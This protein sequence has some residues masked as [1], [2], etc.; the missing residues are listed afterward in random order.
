MSVLFRRLSDE[1]V[2]DRLLDLLIQSIKS[3]DT[4][5]QVSPP[6]LLLSLPPL[7]SQAVRG[8]VNVAEM[9]PLT[10]ISKR[11][12]PALQSLPPYLHDNVPVSGV[13]K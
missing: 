7:Q 13:S 9:I 6:A 5:T 12:L 10:F 3:E 2:E 4:S 11:L 8:L 1:R